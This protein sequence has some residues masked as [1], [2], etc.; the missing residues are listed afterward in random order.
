MH[1]YGGVHGCRGM[2]G[3]ATMAAITDRVR[4][5][6]DLWMVGREGIETHDHSIRSRTLYQLSYRP[7]QVR[8]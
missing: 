5:H 8:G 3:G 1:G 2:R 7:I 6:I 4:T